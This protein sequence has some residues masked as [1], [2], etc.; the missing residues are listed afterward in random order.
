MRVKT[1][2]VGQPTPRTEDIGLLTG[3]GCYADDFRHPGEV[4][5]I[6]VRSA[7]A[8]ADIGSPD[9]SEAL[10]VPGVLAVLTG[11]NWKDDGLGELNGTGFFGLLDPKRRDG[12]D[13]Y[14]PL[15]LPL[16]VDRVRYLGEP[17]AVV[18]AE[19]QNAAKDAAELVNIDYS[20]LP[21]VTGTAAAN[22]RGT[23]QLYDDCERNESF[24][25]EVG[26]RDATDQA[27]SKAFHRVK[28]TFTI[29][30]LHASPIEPRSVLAR[31]D[32]AEGK[33]EIK[34]G[35]QSPND[36]RRSYGTTMLKVDPD[37]IVIETGDVGGSFGMK[38]NNFAE[39]PVLAWASRKLGRPI[40][41]C[42]TRSESFLADTHGRDNVTEGE[43]ALDKDGRFLAF[44]ARTNVAL[45]AY[46]SPAGGVPATLNVGTM[47]GPYTTPTAYVSV[48]GVFTNTNPTS[49]YRG[50]GRPEAALVIERLI[51]IAAAQLEVDPA[52]LRRKNMIPADAFPYK[53]PLVFT[54]DCGDFTSV[55][56]KCQKAADYEGFEARKAHAASRNRL[57]GIGI[58]STIEIAARPG[59]DTAVL[60]VGS[61]GKARVW[62]GST[63]HGQGH[64]TIYRQILS[65]ELG[66]APEDVTVSEG[67]TE[68][69]PNGTGSN[70][71]RSSAF[72]SASV[73][74]ATA[75]AVECGR[76]VA[77]YLLQSDISDIRF[78]KGRYS[79]E[80][81]AATV[82]FAD[83]AK[84]VADP[85]LAELVGGAVLEG[86]G[87]A[88][89][90][91]ANFPNCCHICEVEIDP[92]TGVTE[93][94]GY[95]VVDDVGTELNPMIVK[96]QVHGGVMQGV[97]QA[98]L[99]N[100][101]FDEDGQLLT[102]SYMD[103]AM[104][105]ASDICE[106]AVDSYPVPTATNPYG[107]KGVGESGTVGSLPATMNAIA[108]ALGPLGITHVDTPATPDRIWRLIRNARK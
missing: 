87:H 59:K 18:I 37:T 52:E 65:D 69:S 9:I 72:G 22:A 36:L 31:Y 95:W 10:E 58:A 4:H 43:L 6:F 61:G 82:S 75:K 80:Q 102:G 100:I 55:L 45:G 20:P 74:D 101:V 23:A 38:S 42:S 56:N 5:A 21:I 33:F 93:I 98:L 49:A 63:N 92:D 54:Y 16:A 50:S 60:R 24:V 90:E 8:H 97:G 94:V 78:A 84:A 29:S 1:F 85:T 71:S 25:Y 19:T 73:L 14:R 81:G 96:G 35:A 15:R 64:A 44:R 28:Q 67:N 46:M 88:V 41:W 77:A 30:R 68:L 40:K 53:T 13:W 70:S 39:P 47:A 79:T 91:A 62:A 48:A 108:N 7:V 51:D 107:A 2:S 105:R 3:D 66:I 76:P 32:A 27:F 99:E 34:V 86:T 17:I 11:Q 89:H 57:R 104:P 12:Q 103:Y 106:I 26:D 83:V